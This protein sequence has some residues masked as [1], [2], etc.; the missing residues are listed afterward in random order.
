LGI[1]DDLDI[2]RYEQVIEQ[3]RQGRPA[4]VGLNFPNVE[5]R[6]SIETFK[7]SAVNIHL[8]FFSED[9]DHVDQTTRFLL[10]LNSSYQV[11][12]VNWARLS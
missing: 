11:G 8:L 4:N 7:A 5:L 9:S 10:K 12:P 6:V 3:Q 1:T 2:E